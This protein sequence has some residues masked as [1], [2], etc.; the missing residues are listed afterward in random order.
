MARAVGD[1]TLDWGAWTEQTFTALDGLAN[2]DFE[3]SDELNIGALDNAVDVIIGGFVTSNAAGTSATGYVTLYAA[4]PT[5]GTNYPTSGASAD[6]DNWRQLGPS[7]NVVA[8]A[9]VYR[10]A[11]WSLKQAFGGVLPEKVKI[12]AYNGSGAALDADAADN[13]LF[14]QVVFANAKLS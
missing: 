6:K 10:F 12:G 1:F 7:L 11:G 13:K 5:D 8:N 4:A 2:A 3:A 9:T 14:Y